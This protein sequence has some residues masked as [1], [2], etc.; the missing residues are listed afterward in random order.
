[1]IDNVN[2]ATRALASLNEDQIPAWENQKKRPCTVDGEASTHRFSKR[3][4]TPFDMTDITSA[5]KPLEQSYRFPSIE[6]SNDDDNV[7]SNNQSRL[8]WQGVSDSVTNE[9]KAISKGLRHRPSMESLSGKKA[10]GRNLVR[11]KSK[12]WCL[13][14]LASLSKNSPRTPSTTMEESDRL[15]TWETSRFVLGLPPV[16]KQ[17]SISSQGGMGLR[18]MLA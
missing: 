6:W 5:V 7:S 10:R 2:P 4:R 15:A 18:H 12:T 1:M 13:V 8:S 14:S 3:K 11:S 16:G 9:E 17:E